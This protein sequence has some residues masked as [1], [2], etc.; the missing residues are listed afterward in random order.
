MSNSI[1][2]PPMLPPPLPRATGQPSAPPRGPQPP[3]YPPP[4]P[5]GYVKAAATGALPHDQRLP[6]LQ[7]A[8]DAIKGAQDPGVDLSH[9]HP[10]TLVQAFQCIFNDCKAAKSWGSLNN[11][12]IADKIVSN[13]EVRNCFLEA[14]H[15]D[16]AKNTPLGK[17]LEE[18]K[19][20]QYKDGTFKASAHISKEDLQS[21]L[22]SAKEKGRGQGESPLAS[23]LAV[24]GSI[25]GKESIPKDTEF[26]ISKTSSGDIGLYEVSSKEASGGQKAGLAQ[27]ALGVVLGLLSVLVLVLEVVLFVGCLMGELDY[28]FDTVLCLYVLALMWDDGPVEA[29]APQNKLIATRIDTLKGSPE[30]T[31]GAPQLPEEIARFLAS[32][33][34]K[35]LLIELTQNL[36]SSEKSGL[37]QQWNAIAELR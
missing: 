28:P 20:V 4:P 19:P 12:L 33:N 1:H 32:D 36:T 23:L 18:V 15:Q 13:E 10:A 14:V 3:N 34:N 26:V 22:A 7:S 31:E 5:Y 17:I 24:L 37:F 9:H 16:L 30:A 29:E 2:R 11:P 6:Q 8:I 27:K 35:A 25:R 21:M